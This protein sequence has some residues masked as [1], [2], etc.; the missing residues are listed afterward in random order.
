MALRPLGAPDPLRR[1]LRLLLT[2]A[3]VW[4]PVQFLVWP[5]AQPWYTARVA[6]VADRLVGLLE[7]GDRVTTLRPQRG[8]VHFDCALVPAGEPI[9]SF[10]GD[11]LHFYG[12]LL[13]SL[14][15]VWPGLALRRRAGL[16]AVAAAS[17]FT[18]H[19]IALLI[20]V[21]HTYA[22]TI[23]EVSAPHYSAAERWIW[24]WLHDTFLFFAVQLVPAI[25]LV[26]LFATQRLGRNGRG[27]IAARAA[28]ARPAAILIA[29]GGLLLAGAWT[30][31][32]PRIGA[33]QA[34][35]ASRRG[36]QALRKGEPERAREQFETAL[37]RAPG[38]IDAVVGL[39]DVAAMRGRHTEAA[40]RYREALA[41]EPDRT[42]VLVRLGNALMAAGET[43]GAIASYRG[44]LQRTPSREARVNLAIALRGIGRLD[45]AEPPLR[46]ALQSDPDDAEAL[47]QLAAV[48]IAARRDCEALPILERLAGLDPGTDRM[49][50]V[51]RSVETLRIH[52]G[53]FTPG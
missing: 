21:E 5:H 27:R 48:L 41:R 52:C 49:A 8:F 17:L 23:A 2:L 25:G 3:C 29:V 47:F 10:R 15:L 1:I 20:K 30:L 28:G 22:V 50:L 7:A 37:R 35:L 32:A 53:A 31:H 38:L 19:V 36:T 26:A 24:G 45:E 4:A 42:I 12:V 11:L 44:A 18:F 34:E 14:V 33:R 39:G 6:G 51:T 43:D 13:V 40:Q 16:V 9:T 46:A